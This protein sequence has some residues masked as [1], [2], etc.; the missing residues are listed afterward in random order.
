MKDFRGGAG[1]ASTTVKVTSTTPKPALPVLTLKKSGTKGKLTYK[2]RCFAVCKV[3]ARLTITR[4]TAKKLGLKSRTVGS[5]SRT[6]RPGAT[7]TL[8][9]RLSR[10]VIRAMRR[11]HVRKLK[12][13]LKVRATYAD[14]RRKTAAKKVSIRR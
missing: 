9:V 5:S 8:R 14:G 4:K 10:K 6:I 7:R 11:H 1:H 3:S 12:A 2:V 13:A